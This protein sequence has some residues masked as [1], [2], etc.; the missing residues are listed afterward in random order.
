MPL[1]E[2]KARAERD[3]QGK[4]REK[5]VRERK[6]KEVKSY[7]KKHDGRRNIVS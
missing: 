5:K 6:E 1:V 3:E 4:E 2:K 7:V